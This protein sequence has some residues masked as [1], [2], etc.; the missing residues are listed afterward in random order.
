MKNIAF[1]WAFFLSKAHPS[2][3]VRFGDNGPQ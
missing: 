1:R 2:V 3:A